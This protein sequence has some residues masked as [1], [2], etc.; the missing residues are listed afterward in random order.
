[1]SDGHISILGN[2]KKVCYKYNTADFPWILSYWKEKSFDIITNTIPF[3][4]GIEWLK[5]EC[6]SNINNFRC[7]LLKAD[8]RIF[9]FGLETLLNKLIKLRVII[10]FQKK[11]FEQKRSVSFS[12]K[13]STYFLTGPVA[14]CNWIFY[15]IIELFHIVQI[16]DIV[17]IMFPFLAFCIFTEGFHTRVG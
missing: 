15:G 16:V 17:H 7:L 3:K 2:R 8:F 6:P 5:Y 13:K 12:S 14:W 11:N 10:F 1:M 9:Y 4:N